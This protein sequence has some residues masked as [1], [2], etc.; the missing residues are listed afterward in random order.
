MRWLASFATGLLALSSAVAADWPQWLGPNRDGAT[1]EVVKPWKGELKVLWRAPVGE[2]H[3]SPVVAN[4]LVFLHTKGKNNEQEEVHVW[5]ADNDN[6]SLHASIGF[7]RDKFTSQFGNGPRAT[8]VVYGDRSCFFGATGDLSIL[9]WRKKDDGLEIQQAISIHTSKNYQAAPLMFGVSASPLLEDDKIIV[10]TGGKKGSIVA[11]NTKTHEEAWHALDDPP[12]Y[13]APVAIGKGDQRQIVCL[14]Q[15]RLVSLSP[16]DGELLWEFPFKDQLAESS[17]TPVLVGDL[18]IAS[19]V[20]LGSVAL[21]L[22][23]ISGKPAVEQAWKNPTLTCY[24]STPVHVGEQL[25]MI[26]GSFIPPPSATL[27]C[28][29]TKTGKVL[30]SKAKVGKYH[31]ALI[32]TGDDKLLMLDDSGYLTLIQPDPAGYQELARSKICGE[33]WA[34]PALANGKLY[35]RDN[36]ELICVDL[37]EK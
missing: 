35:V 14:T 12:S 13:A 15:R 4:G 16:K 29:E 24:F 17:T 31:A 18:L 2:G 5:S 9:N 33:T 28:V 3:S 11:F 32:R 22:S 27:R 25:Y 20:T 21:K 34:H 26:N 23:E 8:P 6:A 10:M 30:W 37:G 1:Q 36:K 19:S 7:S